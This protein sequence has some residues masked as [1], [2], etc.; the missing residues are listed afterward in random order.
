[1]RGSAEFLR[2]FALV[3]V[4]IVVIAIGAL[5]VDRFFTVDNFIGILQASSELA[6]VTVA[7]SII[8]IA[9]KFDLSLESTFG[10]APLIG[11][12]LILPESLGGL[13]TEINAYLGLVVI[14]LV[15]VAVGMVN[16]ILIVR[17][18]L[19]AF[20]VTLAMLIL[21]RGIHLGVTNGGT[22]YDLP[23]P[24]TWLGSATIGRMPVSVLFA[25]ALFLAAGL[26]M[27]YF[28]TGRAVYAVG[29]NPAAA[30]AAGINVD[31]IYWIFLTL[32]SMLAAIAGLMFTGRIGA[33]TPDQGKNYIFSVFAAAVIGGISLNGGRGSMLGALTGVLLLGVV[34]N[35][36][37]LSQISSFWIDATYGAIIL[38]ALLAAKL[39]GQE[40]DT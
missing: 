12:W 5:T 40:S 9:G 4:L 17:I 28:R 33:V 8:L 32:G 30:K 29:G 2:N 16:S 3:P 10:L 25:G 22:L 15:G 11:C 13:G 38:V 23:A 1:M 31:R 14:V 37:I 7:L 27:R 20:V 6:V 19:N 36:L 21:L 39:T 26:F 24:I 18:G 35:I 34:S